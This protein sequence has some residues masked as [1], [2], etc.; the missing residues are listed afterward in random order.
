MK[1]LKVILLSLGAG[2]A[3]GMWFG[4]NIGREEP[5]YSNPFDPSSLNQKLK[6]ATGETLEKSGHALE[7]TGQSLQDKLNK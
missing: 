1:Q 6:K 7:K 3:L 2:M 4:V 5:F